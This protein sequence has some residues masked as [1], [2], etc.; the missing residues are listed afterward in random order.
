MDGLS[1]GMNE[2]IGCRDSWMDGWMA[3][4]IDDDRKKTMCVVSYFRIGDKNI[5]ILF[6]NYVWR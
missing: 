5:F 6:M 1:Y 2:W 3:V 4:W